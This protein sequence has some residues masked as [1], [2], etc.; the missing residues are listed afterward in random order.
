D[1]LIDW[2][3]EFNSYIVPFAPFGSFTISRAPQPQL[4]EFLYAL[5]AGDGV[6]GT[7]GLD[8]GNQDRNGEPDGELGVVL[9]QDFAWRDQT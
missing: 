2:A 3:G 7:R 4:A 1:R 9:Q 8:A 6:D 5:G